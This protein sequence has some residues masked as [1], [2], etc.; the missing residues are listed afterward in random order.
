MYRF[1]AA[2]LAGSVKVTAGDLPSFLYLNGQ[3]DRNRPLEGLFRGYLLVR[4]SPEDILLIFSSNNLLP[5]LQS[6]LHGSRERVLGNTRRCSWPAL[7]LSSNHAQPRSSTR[8]SQ[9]YNC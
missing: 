9:L 4:V 7:Y 6:Y 8:F 2:A 1:C 3:Y 5:V